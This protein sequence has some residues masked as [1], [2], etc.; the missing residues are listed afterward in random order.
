VLEDGVIEALDSEHLARVMAPKVDAAINLHELAAGVRLIFFSSA[1][2][3]MGGPGQANYAAANAFL[4]ALAHHRRAE[5]LPAISLAWGA[6][7][8]ATGMTGSLSESDR[9]RLGRLGVVA[10]S[11]AQG[12]ELFDIAGVADRPTLVPMRL[13]AS[14]LRAQASAGMLPA[15]MRSLIRSPLRRNSTAQHTLATRLA[16]T[17]ES[18]WPTITL[19]LVK[20]HVA[21]VLGHDTPNTIEPNRGFTELG[22]YSLDAVELRNRLGHATGLKLPVTV[23]FDYPTP[24]AVTE[25][26]LRKLSLS[27]IA[28][29]PDPREVEIRRVI[30]SIPVSR[31]QG[32]GLLSILL[33]LADSEDV[34]TDGQPASHTSDPTARAEDM[35]ID[36]LV[37]K[38]LEGSD[39][40]SERGL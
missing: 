16:A 1:A 37:A 17:P 18:E 6:W 21:V 13:D 12:L 31:L 34:E 39:A 40:D 27:D 3:T 36:S 4:D 32:S 11:D 14:A 5:G 20:E 19:G 35:D 2:G 25:H 23:I 9:S 10:L 33:D 8:N 38:A 22:I 29:K 26:L 15:M 28:A 30:A 24:L 7:E